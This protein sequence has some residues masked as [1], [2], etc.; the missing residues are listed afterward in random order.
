[1][2]MPEEMRARVRAFLLDQLGDPGR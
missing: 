1:V 2:E